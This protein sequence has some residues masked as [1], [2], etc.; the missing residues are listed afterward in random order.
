MEKKDKAPVAPKNT[1]EIEDIKQRL[2]IYSD[3]ACNPNP[4]YAGWGFHGYLY[5]SAVPKKGSGNANWYLTREGYVSKKE[6]EKE[7]V[8]EITPLQYIDGYGSIN[9]TTTNN[10]AEITAAASAMEYAAGLNI[11]HLDVY[12]DSEYV[13]NG[14][15]EW[16]HHWANNGWISKSGAPIKNVEVWKRLVAAR[17]AL[18]NRGVGITTQWVLGHNGHQGNELADMLADVGQR[19]AMYGKSINSIESTPP[20]GYWNYERE[21][22][23]FLFQPCTYFSTIAS[24]VKPGIYYVGYHDKVDEMLGKRIQDGAFGV[25]MLKHPDPIIETVRNFQ[26]TVSSDSGYI[27]ILKMDRLFKSTNHKLISEHGDIL[28][29]RSGRFNT[30]LCMPN[31]DPLTKECRP[32]MI[33]WR[34]VEQLDFLVAKLQDYHRN[35]P[36]ITVTDLTPILYET[37][38]KTPKKGDPI[39][40]MNFKAEYE[41]GFAKLPVDANYRDAQQEIKTAGI[42]MLLG[43]DLPDRNALKRLEGKNPV[44]TLITWPEAVGAFRYATVIE[45]DGDVGIFAGVYSNL[46]VTPEAPT[47]EPKK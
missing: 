37:T 38:T 29:K 13:V 11:E 1:V 12:T 47:I 7:T 6:V 31:D 8:A 45:S 44:V 15:G 27:V 5:S 23:P 17:D 16:V 41:V 3:G 34:A 24:T 36:S 19:Y 42:I 25:V 14:L 18:R 20:D 9:G 10:V 46:R 2:I 4:G 39:T 43:I 22:H 32:P 28:L 21:R 26:L 40:V 30:D 33:S 35:D